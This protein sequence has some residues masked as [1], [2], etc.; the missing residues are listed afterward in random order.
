MIARTSA[1][2]EDEEFCFF[3]TYHLT[4][5]LSLAS[6]MLTTHQ[7]PITK[8]CISITKPLGVI[9][10][11]YF[12]AIEFGQCRQYELEDGEK[13]VYNCS[14]TLMFT[15]EL[16]PILVVVE[17]VEEAMRDGE[18]FHTVAGLV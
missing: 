17:G 15:G 3:C 13:V 9:Y 7:G 18:F 6:Y 14:G 4:Q 12:E 10:D 5:K 2:F 1:E 11:A 16:E 8:D